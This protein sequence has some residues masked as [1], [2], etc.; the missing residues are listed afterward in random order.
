MKKV[1]ITGLNGYIGGT[2]ARVLREKGYEVSGLVR[3]GEW[4]D[5]LKKEGLRAVTGTMED[6]PLLEREALAADAVIH[7][8]GLADAFAIDLFTT[9]LRGTGKTFI[10]TSGSSLLGRKEYGEASA[11]VYTEDM[12]VPPRLERIHWTG[13]ND[14][15]LRSA[16]YGVRS[17]VIIPTMVYGEGLGIHKES[18]QLPVL[19]KAAREKGMGVYVEKGESIWSN[20]HVKDLAMLYVAAL[21]KA[22]PGSA[23]Y[24]ENGEACFKDIALAMSKKLGKEGDALRLPMEEAVRLFGNEM[25]H[26]GLASNSRCSADKAKA[27][28]QW[29]PEFSSIFDFI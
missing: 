3:N 28:L 6:A 10:H 25:A 13:V 9:V 7:T 27:L 8:A 2:V 4:V 11:V 12:P 1:F 18:I 19:W 5:V 14:H 21:E 26:F 15:V 23:F 20:V 24:V 29:Q 17:V 22:A 16:M